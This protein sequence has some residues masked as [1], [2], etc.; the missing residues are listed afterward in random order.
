MEDAAT[1]LYLLSEDER[2]RME[3]WA[4]E[5][6]LKREQAREDIIAEQKREIAEKDRIIA[7]LQAQLA[8]GKK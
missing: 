7:E 8:V 6:Y 5:D 3:C 1:T 4:R 2:V